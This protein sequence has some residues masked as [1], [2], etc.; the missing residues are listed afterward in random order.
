MGGSGL[1]SA[2]CSDVEMKVKASWHRARQP[3]PYQG[4]METLAKHPVTITLVLCTSF[5][6]KASDGSKMGGGVSVRDTSG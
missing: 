2:M 1:F 3:L 4:E 6:M 5:F